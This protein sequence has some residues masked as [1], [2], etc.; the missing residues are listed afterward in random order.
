MVN[1][2]VRWRYMFRLIKMIDPTISHVPLIPYIKSSVQALGVPGRS[3]RGLHLSILRRPRALT[4]P[5]PDKHM[6]PMCLHFQYHMP[7]YRAF[8]K[9]KDPGSPPDECFDS[10]ITSQSAHR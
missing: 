10:T 1:C 4:L 2:G 5:W 6:Q 8:R 9:Y 3:L 7:C